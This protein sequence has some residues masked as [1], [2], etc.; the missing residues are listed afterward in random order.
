MIGVWLVIEVA[1]L[2][3]LLGCL[4]SNALMPCMIPA[5]I[6][7]MF[8]TPLYPSGVAMTHQHVGDTDDPAT[9]VEPR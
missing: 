1:G 2:L 6:A 5:A 4:M 8:F 9:Y 3:S 7:F